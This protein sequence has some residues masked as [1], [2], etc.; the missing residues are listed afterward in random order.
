M[1]D[2]LL[3]TL[4]HRSMATEFAVILPASL[5]WATEPVL[6][7]LESLDKIEAELTVYQPTSEVSRVNQSADRGPVAV[8]ASTYAV[9]RRA[10]DW[11][12]RTHGAF[13]ITAGPL[14]KAWGFT[15]R[16]GRKPS[17]E[18]IEQA[19][20]QVG[21]QHLILNDSDL[22]I[23][24]AQ[25]NMSINLGGIGKGDALDR[26]AETLVENDVQHFL[27]HGG[28]SSILARGDQQP[29]SEQGWAVGISHPTKPKRR[30]SGIWLRD[31][32]LGTSGSGKQF[33]HHQGRRYGHVIDPRTGYPA[34]DLL[35]LTVVTENATDAD[36]CATG[37]FVNGSKWIREFHATNE[38]APAM[39]CQ[40]AG[41]RQD[42]VKLESFGHFDWVE[43]D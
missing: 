8:S 15:A 20:Q 10:V 42:E 5:G 33:F 1:T 37:L 3:T 14:V 21:Y 22:T 36:A 34:G 41:D 18:E 26:L 2:G 24:F 35:S 16:S 30:V 38:N 6:E 19:R 40:H 31:A 4:T 13:D 28:Q 39:I 12:E 7:A 27:L 25:P 23:Q 43:D 29:G 9:I 32:A 11:S 17:N